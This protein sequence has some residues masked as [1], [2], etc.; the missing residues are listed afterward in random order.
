VD[1]RGLPA[2]KRLDVRDA[3]ARLIVAALPEPGETV[4]LTPE[5]AAHARA[6]RL[7]AGDPVLLLD[8]T[9]RAAAGHVVRHTRTETLVEVSQMIDAAPRAPSAALLVAGLRAERLSWLVEKATELGA[10]RVT[11]VESE[12]TQSFRAAA[13]LLPRLERIAREA[14][15]QCERADWPRIDGPVAFARALDAES[16]P[17]RFL[18]DLDGD[19]FPERVGG[20][21]AAIAIGPEGGWTE[22]ERD[23]ASSRGWRIV[24][25]PAGK[26]RAETA[27]IA[28]MVLL[29]AALEAGKRER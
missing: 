11:I 26:L 13:G 20:A 9:G 25:L 16:A 19:L 27:A 10:A 15:K 3:R 4:R 5:E 24:R 6:R 18:L 12:R 17:E 7:A 23:A 22:S 8:G 28:A 29:R 1:A 21:G 2:G 14:A